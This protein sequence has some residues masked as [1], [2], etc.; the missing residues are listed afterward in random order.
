MP[1]DPTPLCGD[2]KMAGVITDTWQILAGLPAYGALAISFSPDGHGG[3][4]EG[5]V[6]EFSPP[7]SPSWVGNFQR[8]G[9]RLDSV[10]QHPDDRHVIVIAGGQGYVIDPISRE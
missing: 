3:H 10:I 4:S 8:G 2:G 5:L 7:A 6:V 9:G 1:S